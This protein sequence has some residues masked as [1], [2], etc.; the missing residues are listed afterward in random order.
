MEN[1]LKEKAFNFLSIFVYL[2]LF[3]ASIF[4]FEYKDLSIADI[5][6]IDAVLLIF[7]TYRISRMIVYEKVFGYFRYLIRVRSG[8][9]FFNSINNLI[10]CPWCTSVWIALFF[11]DIYYMVPYGNYFIYL[12]VISALA[13]PLILLSNYLSLQND[14]LKKRRDG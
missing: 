4:L 5:S 8:N 2:V 1:L 6:I 3:I 10:T 14:I 9:S 11:F 7:A 12:M 13:S